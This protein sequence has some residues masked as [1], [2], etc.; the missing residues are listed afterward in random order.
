[1]Q[2]MIDICMC[3]WCK[4]SHVDGRRDSEAVDSFWTTQPWWR[5]WH[6]AVLVEWW[7]Q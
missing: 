1:V 5:I 7:K 4:V 6:A 2:L 3:Y